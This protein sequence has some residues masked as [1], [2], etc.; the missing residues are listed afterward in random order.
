MRGLSHSDNCPPPN[1]SYEHRKI[2][3]DD[4]RVLDRQ[5]I[6]ETTTAEKRKVKFG[7]R[8]FHR[9]DE[10]FSEL[11]RRAQFV[12]KQGFDSAIIDDHLLYGTKDASAPDPF[13]SLAILASQ[14][15]K[16][17][18]GI[19][20]T[21]LVRRHPA[22]VAQSLATL[23]VAY[24]SRIFLGLGA[25]D[26]M[27]Q[28]PFGFP[29]SHRFLKLREGLQLLRLLWNSSFAIPKSFSGSFYKLDKAYLQLAQERHDMP[30]VYL[31]AF[32]S[33][34]LEL[35]GREADGW[36][37]HCHTPFTYRQDLEIIKE[38]RRKQGKAKGS[39]FHP[40]YYTLASSAKNPAIADQAVIGPAKYFLAL[41]PEALNK[42]DATAHHPG[43]VWEKISDPR[44]QREMIRKIADT[45][46]E[47]DAF[48]TVIHGSPDDCI[49]Q[50]D[51]YRKAGCTEFMLTFATGGGLWSTEKLFEQIRFFRR[52]VLAY[53]D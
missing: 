31:A 26:P 39:L 4:Y 13:T 11:V 20:V 46:P 48:E 53:Y 21:D 36:I 10:Q 2:T 19:M 47:K 50:I 29:T 27:N 40:A 14:T 30:P 17:R 35:T 52:R 45:I 42:I 18:L 16:I 41:I 37:P 38:W 23:E 3:A 5:F 1:S 34:M 9:S 8:I 43:R 44:V 15:K 25:G 7:C 12:E 32:G 28:T 6:W 33:K 49:A 51:N 22:I 24:P